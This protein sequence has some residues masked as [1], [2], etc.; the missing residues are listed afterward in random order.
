M[1][2]ALDKVEFYI[3]G[4][5]STDL[6]GSGNARCLVIYDVVDGSARKDGNSHEVDSPDWSKTFHNTGAVGE[7]VRDTLDAIKTA[8]GI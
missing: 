1:A 5:P 2:R 7:F 4:D 8:E 3:S 6:D